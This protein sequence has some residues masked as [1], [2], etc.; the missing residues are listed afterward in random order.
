M[1]TCLRVGLELSTSPEESVQAKLPCPMRIFGYLTD[2]N[3]IDSNYL[4]WGENPQADCSD[5]EEIL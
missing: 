2:N 1:T 4:C 5:M 3:I